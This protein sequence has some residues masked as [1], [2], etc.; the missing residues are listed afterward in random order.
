MDPS[1]FA[2]D[3][4]GR[5]T[6]I[7]EGHWAYVPDPLPPRL[8]YNPELVG[9][10][11][12]ADRAL[13]RLAG[14]GQ[15]LPNPH[16]VIR[17]FLRREAVLS[18]RI[19]GTIATIEQL[20]LFEAAPTAEASDAR[21]VY[22]YMSALE[23]A[24]DR[25]QTLPVSLRLIRELHRRLMTGVRGQERSPGEFRRIQNA[26][27]QRGRPVAEAQFVPPPVSE[28]QTALYSF[29]RFLADPTDLPPLIAIAL[30]HYQ[31]ET[32]HPFMDGNGRIGRL[33]ISLL[34]CERELL[35]QPLLYLSA[36]FERNR[37]AY[38]DHLL[39][40]S[41][42]GA[43]SEWIAF[44]LRGVAEQAHDALKRSERLLALAQEFRQRLQTARYTGLAFRLADELFV[45]PI[46]SMARAREVLNVTS[47]AAQL[48]IEKLQQAGLIR[49]VTGRQRYRLYVCPE[50]IEIIEAPDAA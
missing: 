22:N 39:R 27:G 6:C 35:S 33:L 18:S 36:Y 23:Y 25:L 1:D 13:G 2:A 19:E 9:L 43:W 46:M 41:Q 15:R 20:A 8:T 29:E 32:I 24:L 44:F 10:L 50:L 16:L 12:E 40:V 49:E 4:P 48:N 14:V 3:M 38:I 31:F 28:M 47:R 21:E 34:L 37:D 5:L 45:S 7:S 26:I 11:S 17:P 42:R 30:A